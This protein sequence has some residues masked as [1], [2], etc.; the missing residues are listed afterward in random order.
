MKVMFGGQIGRDE[1]MARRLL[2]SDC[3]LYTAAQY[4]NPGLM[5]K[6]E[7][8]GGQFYPNIDITSPSPMAELAVQVQPELFYTNS[9][10][11]LAAGV[12]NAIKSVLPKVLI[13]SPTQE[14]ARIESDKFEAREIVASIDDKYNPDYQVATNPENLEDAIDHFIKAGKP[15]AV[16]PRGLTGGKGV[17]VMGKHFET[18]Q[19]AREYALQ[20]LA[21]PNQK[22]VVLEEKLEGFEFTIQALTDGKILIVPPATYDYPYREDGDAGPGTGGMGCFTIADGLLPFLK[23]SDYD[24]AIGLMQ[25]VQARLAKQNRAVKGTLYGSFFMTKEGLKLVEFNVRLGDPEGINIM[26]LLEDDVDM[27]EV[28]QQIARA[29]LDEKS[30][31]FKKAASAVIY[32]VSPEY[33]HQDKGPTYEFDLDPRVIEVHDCRLYFAAAERIGGNRFKNVGNSRT[34]AVGTLAGTPWEARAKIHDALKQGYRGKLKYR[35]DIASQA[36]IESLTSF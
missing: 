34:F 31:R 18:H 5:A 19:E 4:L 32:L 35:P 10:D 12:V 13:A 16:K 27:L 33:A 24:E 2:D 8:S 22:G 11:A 14:E 26:E 25:K 28:L 7:A 3:Q 1:A 9:D 30:I 20:V 6:V 29:E 23:Q 15:V 36:Y 21:N 17:K